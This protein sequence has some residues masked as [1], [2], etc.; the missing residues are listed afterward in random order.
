[1]FKYSNTNKRY[2][3]LD[4]YYKHRFSS[5]VA[6]IN[7]DANFTC[8][9]I[10]GKKGFGGCIYCLNGSS[11]FKEKVPLLE[12]FQIRKKVMQNKWPNSKLIGYFQANSNT[13]ADSLSTNV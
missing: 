12:Q 1:M 3:T 5:K 11:D 4:Y 2:Y 10:D 8:P 9:N 13:Y 7:L 6:K